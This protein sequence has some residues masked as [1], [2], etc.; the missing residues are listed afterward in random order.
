VT[1][2]AT[3]AELRAYLPQVPE[4]GQQLITLTGT[5]TGRTRRRFRA[6]SRPTPGR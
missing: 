2:Y 6:R 3:V 1:S 5:P 4:Y